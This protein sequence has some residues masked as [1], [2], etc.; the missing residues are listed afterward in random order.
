M[1]ALSSGGPA[2]RAKAIWTAER[3]SKAAAPQLLSN[4]QR[5]D[6]STIGSIVRFKKGQQIYR[7]GDPID[8]IYNVISG[9]VKS[10]SAAPGGRKRI[11]AFLFPEDMFGLA[12]AGRYTNSAEAITAVTA[13]RFPVSKLQTHLQRDPGL[14]FHVIC[15]LCQDLRYA[16]R[17][18]FIVATKDALHKLAMFL[19]LL[20]EL[21][22]SRGEP[23]NEIYLPIA[24]TEIGEFIGLSLAAVSRA[25]RTLSATRIVKVRNRRHVQI[26][27]RTA[28]D[29]LLGLT[30]VSGRGAGQKAR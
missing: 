17:H 12:E 24:R 27:D 4:Q 15:K 7:A 19:R 6:L 26:T 23:T 10:V 25:F 29:D 14:E 30:R 3:S 22:A 16:Q 21:Q 1:I 9:G 2:I 11:N 28:F 20:E 18:A 13:Y 5:A 8:A